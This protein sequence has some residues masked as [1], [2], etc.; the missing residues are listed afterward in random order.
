ML[1]PQG[2]NIQIDNEKMQFKGSIWARGRGVNKSGNQ[3]N[4]LS[5]AGGGFKS[6]LG[7]REG[8]RKLARD[9]YGGEVLYRG[10]ALVLNR[11]YL[12]IPI[13]FELPKGGGGY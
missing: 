12:G 9:C 6:P 4:P 7:R 10:W 13:G 11:R 3:R 8:G 1:I 5:E 2:K